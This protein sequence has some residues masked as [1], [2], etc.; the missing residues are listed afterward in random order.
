M[1]LNSRNINSGVSIIICC[2]NSAE[3]IKSTLDK[4]FNQRNTLRINI[5]IIV[6]D[7]NSTDNT[8]LIASEALAAQ[9]SFKSTIV[10][11]K[12]QGLVYAR[13]RGIESASYSVTIFCDDDNWLDDNYI[14]TAYTFMNANTQVGMLGGQISPFANIKIPSWFFTYG[15][16]YAVGVPRLSSGDT[17]DIGYVWGAGSVLRTEFLKHMY[18]SNFEPL[19]SGR[20]GTSLGAGDDSE[21]A[22]WV[23]A[24]GYRLWYLD[25]L[26]LSHYMPNSRLEISK[27]ILTLESGKESVKV[28]KAYD[29]AVFYITKHISHLK[30][31]DYLKTIYAILSAGI[32]FFKLDKKHRDHIIY[33][34]RRAHGFCIK[35][36][37]S[38]TFI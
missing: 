18:S 13:M 10:H 28:L 19:L 31:Q 8:S 9:T 20:S 15:E 5:E 36:S 12:K 23:I 16:K 24:S 38:Q 29:F 33:H 3:R 25:E 17:T 14:E 35:S 2:F 7:N 26:H 37:D 34:T 4:I 1:K 30:K 11:E 6:V 27:L 21:I 22:K 32:N